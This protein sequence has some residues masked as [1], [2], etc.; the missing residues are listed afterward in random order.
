MRKFMDLKINWGGVT[1]NRNVIYGITTL[2]IIV[3]HFFENYLENYSQGAIYWIGRIY[4][5]VIGSIGVDIFVLLSGIGLYFSLSKDKNIKSF[6][7]K[8]IRRILYPS[9][10]IMLIYWIIKD[11]IIYKCTFTEFAKDYFFVTFISDGKRV[12]WYV[13]FVI[14]SYAIYPL[15]HKFLSVDDAHRKTNIV[16]LLVAS[17]MGQYIPR[18]FATTLYQNIEIMLCRFLPLVM[19]AILGKHVLENKTISISEMAILMIGFVIFLIGRI[20]NIY[21]VFEKIGYRNIECLYGLSLLAIISIIIN[22]LKTKKIKSFLSFIGVYSFEI[23]LSHVA[24]RNLFNTCG[25]YTYNISNYLICLVL[26]GFL[27]LCLD[28]FKKKVLL[29]EK[30][31]RR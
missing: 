20:D 17:I 14:I 15:I 10:S 19:G 24:I 31:I 25:L 22:F 7:R 27:V 26:S 9:V 30:C 3:F 11:F 1:L 23:Y 28:Q 13:L 16:I 4:N 5:T 8:R 29:N 18:L 12:F 2:T 21:R 6:Y